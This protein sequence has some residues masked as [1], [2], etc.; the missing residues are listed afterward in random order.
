METPP[1]PSEARAVVSLKAMYQGCMDTDTIE[2]AGLGPL[3][4]A[5]GEGGDLGGWPMV[6]DNWSGDRWG[7][8]L[9][10]KIFICR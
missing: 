4:A 2:A 5:A 6:Q 1:H 7:W 8:L 3:L 9:I 10:Y